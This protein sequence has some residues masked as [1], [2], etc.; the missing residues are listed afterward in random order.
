MQ[1][2]MVIGLVTAYP[3]NWWLIRPR[4]QGSDVKGP[5]LSESTP[6]ALPYV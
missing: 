5:E 3:A 1:I 4:V 6:P 2:A